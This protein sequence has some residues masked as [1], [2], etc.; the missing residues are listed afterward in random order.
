MFSYIVGDLKTAKALAE[1]ISTLLLSKVPSE[2]FKELAEAID[3]EIKAKSDAKKEK[4]QEKVK[5]AFVKLFYY[6]V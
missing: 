2:I 3:E 6:A 4:A 5:I 1:S